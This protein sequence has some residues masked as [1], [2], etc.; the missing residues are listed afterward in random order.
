MG[1]GFGFA[2]DTVGVVPC[3][4]DGNGTWGTQE[5]NFFDFASHINYATPQSP[6]CGS[7]ECFPRDSMEEPSSTNLLLL[8]PV[9]RHFLEVAMSHYFRTDGFLY[10]TDQ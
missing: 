10:L 2:E 9:V 5:G 1:V 4:T 7:L 6:M 8:Y 3:G